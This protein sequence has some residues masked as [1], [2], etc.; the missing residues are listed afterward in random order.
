M[1]CNKQ[2]R[3]RNICLI[4][5]SSTYKVLEKFT[6]GLDSSLPF[7]QSWLKQIM[8]I[9]ADV[10]FVGFRSSTSEAS[11]V[12]RW[13]HCT[14]LGSMVFC[15][16]CRSHSQVCLYIIVYIFTC[17]LLPVELGGQLATENG[18]SK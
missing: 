12:Q 7:G 17:S 18:D 2:R 6:L 3:S 1:V 10:G 4:R 9:S 5:S 14:V 13:M 8:K 15:I 16:H 11:T